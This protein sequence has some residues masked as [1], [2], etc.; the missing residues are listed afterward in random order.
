MELVQDRP[1]SISRPGIIILGAVCFFYITVILRTLA[2]APFLAAW[3]PVYLGLEVLFGILFALVLW[4]PIPPGP[5]S[6]LYQ[7]SPVIP[8]RP[9]PRDSF[10]TPV[11]FIPLQ[12]KPSAVS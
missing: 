6:Y 9:S 7:S 12:T 4:R 1:R 5:L 3:L 8:F 10:A 2:E 11:A